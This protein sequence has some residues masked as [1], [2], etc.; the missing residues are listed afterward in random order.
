MPTDESHSLN[1]PPLPTH[2]LPAFAYT[3]T[4][5]SSRLSIDLGYSGPRTRLKVRLRL[6]LRRVFGLRPAVLSSARHSPCAFGARLGGAEASPRDQ[7]LSL[8]LEDNPFQWTTRLGAASRVTL[9]L[10]SEL[11]ARLRD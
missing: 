7:H 11:P 5:T 10:N 4:S 8:D 1:V 9:V 6:R 2:L 3:S